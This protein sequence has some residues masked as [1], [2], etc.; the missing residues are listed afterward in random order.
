MP[1]FEYIEFLFGLLAL[2]PLSL[3]F[4]FV[5]RWKKKTKKA[6]GDERLI[7]QLTSNYSAKKY[8]LKIIVVLV[9]IA[10]T[11]VAA[12]NLRKPKN[13]AGTKGNGIDI[14]FALDVS[15]SMLSEDEKPNRLAKAQQLI[16]ELTERL[17]GN[18]IGFVVFAGKAYLQM[19]LTSD[20]SAAKMFVSNASPDLVNVQ[21]T[22]FSDALDLCDASLDTKE[23]KSKAIVLITDGEDHDEKAEESAKKLAEHGTVLYTVGV[24]S[25]EGTPIIEPGTNEYKRDANGQT[26]IT[27]LN[28]Q[29]LKKLA[30]DAGGNYYALNNTNTVA[31]AL[32]NDLNTLEKKP[33]SNAGGFIEYQ[34]FYPYFLALA[35][36]LLVIEVFISE[37]KTKFA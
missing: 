4:I 34:S 29:L 30:S 10:L 24:G 12:A 15:K 3:L 13:T 31:T 1:Q 7:N 20:V 26:I 25:A 5:L 18:R 16:N 17:D 11:I 8:R 37:R 23:K 2:L 32:T 14:I 19:P 21:G 36:L 6:L 27:K 33:I 9:A 35:V 28:D 22:V